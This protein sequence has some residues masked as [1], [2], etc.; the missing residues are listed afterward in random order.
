MTRVEI[1]YDG[2]LYSI[3]NR[4]AASVRAEVAGAL[5]SN[6][7]YWLEVQRGEG[8]YTAAFLLIAPGIA[9]AVTEVL[10]GPAS[11]PED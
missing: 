6:A 5:A 1:V 8:D 9:F 4:D 10:S 11:P 7:P 3:G 2:R